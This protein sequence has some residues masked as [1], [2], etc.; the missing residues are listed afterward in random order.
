MTDRQK[1]LAEKHGTPEQFEKAI[2][3]A[4]DDLF[5]TSGEADAAIKKYRAEW[6]A[7]GTG[8]STVNDSNLTADLTAAERDRIAYECWC[9]S[10]VSATVARGTSEQRQARIDEDERV[11]EA[12]IVVAAHEH[13]MVLLDLEAAARRGGRGRQSKQKQQESSRETAHAHTLPD[14]HIA[15]PHVRRPVRRLALHVAVHHAAAP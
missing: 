6:D 11:G 3:K 9:E 4:W 10:R 1:E 12:P 15:V 8:V 13:G 2:W 14:G 5:I 7:A